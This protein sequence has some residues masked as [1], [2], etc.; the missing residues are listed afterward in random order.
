MD[1]K[2]IVAKRPRET[3]WLIGGAP[4]TVCLSLPIKITVGNLKHI[5]LCNCC[6]S[7]TLVKTLSFLRTLTTIAELE[8]TAGDR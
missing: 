3:S 1:V 8:I 6:H 5:S 7:T 4:H 2:I